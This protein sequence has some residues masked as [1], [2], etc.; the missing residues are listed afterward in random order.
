MD[1][2]QAAATRAANAK[3]STLTPVPAGGHKA[4]PLPFQVAALRERELTYAS[5]VKARVAP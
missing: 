5:S 4:V 2:R 3:T 1:R